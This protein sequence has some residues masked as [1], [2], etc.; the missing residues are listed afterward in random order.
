MLTREK[1]DERDDI[2]RLPVSKKEGRRLANIEDYAD[3]PLKKKKRTQGW[4]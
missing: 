3:V 1:K 2:V 4:H